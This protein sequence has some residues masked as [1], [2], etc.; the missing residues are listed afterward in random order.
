MKKLFLQLDIQ[1]FK[2]KIFNVYENFIK[3][4]TNELFLQ[5]NHWKIF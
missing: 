5:I 3:F 2:N 4:D 1:K